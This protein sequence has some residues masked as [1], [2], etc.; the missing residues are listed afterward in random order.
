VPQPCPGR[1]SGAGLGPP[2][3]A[4]S[5]PTDELLGFT[6]QERVEHVAG[7]GRTEDLKAARKGSVAGLI[8]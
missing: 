1:A 8:V 2:E 3:E 7:Q 6:P 5:E 4:E